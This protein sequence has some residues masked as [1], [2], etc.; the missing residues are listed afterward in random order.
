MFVI[1]NTLRCPYQRASWNSGLW[2]SRPAFEI[3]CL[4]LPQLY[5]HPHA[6]I[7]TNTHSHTSLQKKSFLFCAVCMASVCT[8]KAFCPEMQGRHKLFVHVMM[9]CLLGSSASEVW[10]AP[11]FYHL[12]LFYLTL[13]VPPSF[14]VDAH[15]VRGARH[16]ALPIK[17]NNW[18]LNQTFATFWNVDVKSWIRWCFTVISEIRGLFSVDKIPISLFAVVTPYELEKHADRH[19]NHDIL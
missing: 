11:F 19:N 10:P 17:L 9:S 7:L 18:K 6:H 3:G 14:K 2:V 1:I 4:P 13:Q 5:T 15:H 12:L 8:F 16:W